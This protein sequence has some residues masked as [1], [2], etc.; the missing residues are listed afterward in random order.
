MKWIGE[1]LWVFFVFS[2]RAAAVL[3]FLAGALW[4]T[5]WIKNYDQPA[6]T[7]KVPF[8]GYQNIILDES[9][10]VRCRVV[11]RS[12]PSCTML[13]DCDDGVDRCV[14]TFEILRRPASPGDYLPTE[15]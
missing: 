4:F 6:P 9:K 7:P 14:G 3:C 8:D 10:L 11:D 5:I 15:E 12:Q 2:L 1:V 13:S